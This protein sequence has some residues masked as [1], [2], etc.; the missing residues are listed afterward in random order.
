MHLSLQERSLAL[1]AGEGDRTLSLQG[2]VGASRRVRV[3][4]SNQK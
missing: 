3:R 1:A 2:E 4:L